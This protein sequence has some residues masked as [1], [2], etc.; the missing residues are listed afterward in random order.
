MGGSARAWLQGH[1]FSNQLC[2]REV[3]PDC[4]RRPPTITLRA[5]TLT[6]K[7]AFASLQAVGVFFF[8]SSA[9][10]KGKVPDLG[11]IFVLRQRAVSLLSVGVKEVS[12]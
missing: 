2:M 12:L 1:T 11:S 7:A 6:Q 3:P 5:K 10:R 4:D 8:I 9:W